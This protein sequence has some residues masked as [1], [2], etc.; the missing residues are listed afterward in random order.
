MKQFYFRFQEDVIIRPESMYGGM[1]THGPL[2]AFCPTQRPI[3]GTV[4]EYLQ[5]RNGEDEIWLKD[6][7]F[8]IHCVG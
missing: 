1:V 6:S 4:W 5:G 3:E 2:G 8:R 7:N